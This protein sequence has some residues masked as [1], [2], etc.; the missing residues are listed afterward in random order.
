MS[1]FDDVKHEGDF[2]GFL[3]FSLRIYL[4]DND[5]QVKGLKKPL[6]NLSLD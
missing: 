6:D 1:L 2:G 4:V 5:L 3:Q